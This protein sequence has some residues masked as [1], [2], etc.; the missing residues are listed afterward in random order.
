VRDIESLLRDSE[1]RRA[2]LYYALLLKR[3]KKNKIA[4]YY[5]SQKQ[6]SKI[7]EFHTLA[8]LLPMIDEIGF[9]ALKADIQQ[10]GLIQPI[11]LYQGKI[12]DGRNRYKACLAVGV[13]PVFSNYEGAE[14]GLLNFVLSLNLQRRHLST[15]QKA[16]L[17]VEVLPELERQAKE[18]LRVK[19][20][21]IR[22]GEE[23]EKSEKSRNIAAQL[24]G[25]SGGSISLAKQIRE[26]SIELFNLVKS[27][28][29]TLQKAKLQLTQKAEDVSKLTQPQPVELTKIELRRIAELVAE[30][31]ITEDKARSYVVKR[32]KQKQE[33]SKET[34]TLREVKFRITE[35]VKT[36]LQNFAKLQGKPI[37][38]VL[39]NLLEVELK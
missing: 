6:M 22:K 27:N 34:T 7:L 37:S 38:E 15:G 1:R 29:L 8:N 2:P 5:R 33:R 25:V 30:L 32:R 10:N 18:R 3:I 9:E 19:I 24:F 14:S 26:S 21:A 35:D 16:C 31:G 17:A 23:V 13:K 39:R 12:I 36:R 11:Y 4:N 28:E 20:S